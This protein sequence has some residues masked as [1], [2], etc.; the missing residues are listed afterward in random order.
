MIS[1]DEITFES[2]K[3]NKTKKKKMTDALTS[4]QS[5]KTKENENL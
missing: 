2:L 5:M 3:E 1:T 4:V